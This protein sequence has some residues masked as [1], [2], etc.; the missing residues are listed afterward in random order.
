MQSN[1]DFHGLFQQW[2]EKKSQLFVVLFPPGGQLRSLHGTVRRVTAAEAIIDGGDTV[3][4]IPLARLSDG[5]ISRFSERVQS[6]SLTWSD[7]L[8]AFV[9]ARVPAV[10]DLAGAVRAELPLEPSDAR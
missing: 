9:V 4:A 6:V 8:T 10:Q 3:A 7:G 2:A 5:R 1:H